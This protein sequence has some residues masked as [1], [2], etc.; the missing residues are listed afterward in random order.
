MSALALVLAAPVS[1]RG[2]TADQLE[3][4]GWFCF[5]VRGLG[6]HCMPPG[7]EF[8]DRHVQLLYFDGAGMEFKGVESLVRADA[9]KGNRQ[10]RTDPSGGW[11]DLT[12]IGYWGCHRN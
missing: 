5:P 4:A 1:A 3:D 2:L 9:F 10:C 8:G 11:L 12:G 7:V 6:V